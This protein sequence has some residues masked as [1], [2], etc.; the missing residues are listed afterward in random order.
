MKCSP[1]VG[2]AIE[3]ACAR[4]HRLIPLAIAVIV[5]TLDVRRQR[6]P[7]DRVHGLVHRHHAVGPEAHDPTAERSALQNLSVQDVDSVEHHPRARLQFLPG[8]NQRFPDLR[9]QT[10]SGAGSG[11]ALSA[12]CCPARSGPSER[13]SRNSTPPPL[14]NTAADQP[15]RKHPRVVDDDEIAGAEELGNRGDLRMDDRSGGTI[16]TQQARR[17]ALRRRLLRDQFRGKVEI[18]LADV[19]P[20]DML[21]RTVIT[22]LNAEHADHAENSR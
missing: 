18:E 15:R 5:V 4:K 12:G 9:Q 7:A 6:H 19:H 21:P 8:V 1:A 22:T 17:A 20:C 14:G 2:A 3:P 13:I 11:E 16:E 10:T